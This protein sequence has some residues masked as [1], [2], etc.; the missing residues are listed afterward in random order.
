MVTDD[1]AEVEARMMTADQCRDA[2]YKHVSTCAHCSGRLTR[3]GGPGTGEG[4]MRLGCAEGDA[5]LRGFLDRISLP[6]WW[7]QPHDL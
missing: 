5:Y 3:K 7:T 1:E 4:R 6:T 2:W